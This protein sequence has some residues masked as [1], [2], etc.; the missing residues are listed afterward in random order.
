MRSLSTNNFEQSNIQFIQFWVL[1]PFN[2]DAENQNPN[3]LHNGGDMYFNLGNISEDILPD[4][5]KS[6]EN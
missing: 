6:Y 1:D 4:S 5:Y 2:E 3:S